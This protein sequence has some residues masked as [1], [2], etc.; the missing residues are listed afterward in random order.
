MDTQHV[1]TDSLRVGSMRFDV[2][3]YGA[4]DGVPVLAGVDV[5]H[6]SPMATLPIGGEAELVVGDPCRFRL[7]RH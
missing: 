1:T 6:T 7:T 3:R 4:A 2:R 5:G